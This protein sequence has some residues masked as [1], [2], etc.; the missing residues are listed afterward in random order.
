MKVSGGSS[1]LYL[2]DTISDDGAVGK[3]KVNQYLPVSY[4]LNTPDPGN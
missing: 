3:D 4:G 2:E 1:R